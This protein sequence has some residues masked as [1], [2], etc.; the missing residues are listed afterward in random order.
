MKIF[1][2]IPTLAVSKTSFIKNLK[3]IKE[4]G[5]DMFYLDIINSKET[6]IFKG[7]LS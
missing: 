5:S 1:S 2:S 3:L 7:E 6:T 4:L